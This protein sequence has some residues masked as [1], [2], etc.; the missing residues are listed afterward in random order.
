MRRTLTV[1]GVT[2]AA[3]AAGT[4]ST[5][6][7]AQAMNLEQSVVVNDN[8]AD[9]TP[10]VLDGQVHAIAQVGTKIVIGGTFTKIQNPGGGTPYTKPYIA[11][12]DATTGQVDTAFNPVLD[13]RVEAL[14]AVGTSVVVGGW[15]NTVNGVS[16][17]GITKLSTL[18]GARDVA[19]NASLDKS[20]AGSIVNSLAV[21]GS[22]L[23]IGG[24]FVGINKIKRSNLAAL[25]P[26]TGAVDAGFNLPVTGA[27][28]GTGTT[29]PSVQVV[30]ASPNGAQLVV[31]G[32]FTTVAGQPRNQVAVISASSNSLSSWATAEFADTCNTP[33]TIRTYVRDIDFAPDGSYFVVVTTGG[34]VV[35]SLCD[36]ASRWEANRTGSGQLPTWVD[37][38]G[39]DS[40]TAVAATGTTIYVG[41]HQKY[42]NNSNGSVDPVTQEAIPGPGA[43]ERVGLA[44]LDPATGLPLAWNPGRD[45]G[46]GVFDFLATSDGLWVGSDTTEIGTPR[47]VRARIAYFPLAGGT[48]VKQPAPTNLPNTLFIAQNNDSLTKASFSGSVLGAQSPVSDPG[49]VNWGSVTGAFMAAGKV[50]YTLP[51]GELWSVPFNGATV[52]AAS[53]VGSNWFDFSGVKGATLLNGRLYYVKNNDGRLYYRWFTTTTEIVGSREYTAAASGFADAHTLFSGGGYLY[54]AKADNKLY[55][56]TPGP[57][58]APTGAPIE[59]PGAGTAWN[60]PAA[61]LDSAVL[62]QIDRIYGADRVATSIAASQ[63]Q[64]GNGAADAVVLARAD[65]FPDGLAGAALAADKNGPLMLT[66]PTAL[67]GRVLDEIMRVLP[68]GKTVYLLGG[69]GALSTTVENAVKAAPG[70]SYTVK[71]LAGADRTATSIA[72]ANEVSSPSKVLLA[73]GFDFPDALGAGAAAGAK[74][75]VVLLTAGTKMP[76]SITTWLSGKSLEVWAVGGPAATA[77]G[78]LVDPSRRIVGADRFDTAAKLATKFFAS[79]GKVALA[80]GFNYPDGLSGGGYAANEGSPLL[81]VGT[82]TMPTATLNYLKANADSISGGTA[83]GGPLVI[84]ESV[85]KAAETAI[86]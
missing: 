50:Y 49:S 76:A 72:I 19:F 17:R 57:T 21:R 25:N 1:V 59:V 60:V 8:P 58:G 34:R 65:A 41:G 74:N 64:F 33:T 73:T 47:E 70:K 35:G 51:N 39:G 38:T 23:F 10:Q 48:P 53:K 31:S 78:S 54:Y 16:Q 3:L 6:P 52:G 62:Q 15:F 83:F 32:N 5:L 40:L 26:A 66:P 22:R 2:V 24:R 81:L 55:R 46:E 13:G 56:V 11:A 79:P 82:T 63:D 37:E 69:T 84:S 36:S 68:A 42:L 45:R 7:A 9:F 14:E 86:N 4:L 20:T 75:G 71:R 43:V 12:F 29:T 18:T 61:F 85:L 28:P 30:S 27:R 80:T 77:A 44:A 67:D